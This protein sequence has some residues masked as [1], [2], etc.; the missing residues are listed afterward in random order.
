MKHL[1]LTNFLVTRIIEGQWEIDDNL[2]D[3]FDEISSIAP[4]YGLTLEYQTTIAIGLEKYA[5]QSCDECNQ[6]MLNRSLNP[7][8]FDQEE[9]FNEMESIIYDGA[10][11]DGKNL[12][13]G[14][15]PETHRWGIYLDPED[16]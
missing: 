11:H 9:Y 12:C 3:L 8:G 13:A 7:V 10:E 15:L 1:Q 5:I 4:K 16:S 6:R 2:Q 14:C